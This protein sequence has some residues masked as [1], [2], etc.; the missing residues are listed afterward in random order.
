MLVVLVFILFVTPNSPPLPQVHVLES[1]V[2]VFVSVD[3]G[4]ACAQIQIQMPHA[5]AS[6]NAD[7]NVNARAKVNAC[8]YVQMPKHQGQEHWYDSVSI[9]RRISYEY[10]ATGKPPTKTLSFSELL[11]LLV[12]PFQKHLYR[13]VAQKRRGE[14]YKIDLVMSSD[15]LSSRKGSASSQRSMRNGKGNSTTTRSKANAKRQKPNAKCQMP[16][17]KR[18]MPNAKRQTPNA[19][20][21][22]PKRTRPPQQSKAKQ[23]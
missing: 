7:V 13:S 23:R 10:R 6:A 8:M 18:H 12:Q 11:F 15:R 16:K 9:C 1:V 19:K 4:I 22:T 2:V 5:K 14:K 17:A 20:R 21:Q 3:T